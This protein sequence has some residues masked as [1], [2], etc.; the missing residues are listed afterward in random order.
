FGIPGARHVAGGLLAGLAV[1]TAGAGL[2]R[3][4][5]VDHAIR[6]GLPLPPHGIPRLLAGGLILVALLGAVLVITTAVGR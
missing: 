2:R 1:I 5:R 6:R 4:E 3:W